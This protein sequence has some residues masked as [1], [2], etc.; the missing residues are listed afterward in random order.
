MQ[1]VHHCTRAAR[2]SAAFV[3]DL[4]PLARQIRSTRLRFTAQPP[5]S[6]P[7]SDD[8]HNGRTGQPRDDVGGQR[9]LVIQGLRVLRH[10]GLA[11]GF[12]VLLFAL[13]IHAIVEIKAV[14]FTQ[15]VKGR[16]EYLVAVP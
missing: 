4:E 16:H 1:E 8:S 7:R 5:R 2:A 15:R 12:S 14:S 13:R 3:G 6:M 9:R 11:T 10:W